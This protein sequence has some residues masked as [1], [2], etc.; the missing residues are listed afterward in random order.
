MAWLIRR[1]KNLMFAGITASDAI[2]NFI[3]LTSQEDPKLVN[4]AVLKFSKGQ[5]IRVNAY[6]LRWE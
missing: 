3:K 4:S 5:N 1:N 6:T 2:D